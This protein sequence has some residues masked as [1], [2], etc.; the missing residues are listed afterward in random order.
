MSSGDPIAAARARLAKCCALLSWSRV[1]RQTR[2]L[3]RSV[4]RHEF[5]QRRDWQH[6]F[7]HSSSH[8]RPGYRSPH[9]RGNEHASVDLHEPGAV[10]YRSFAEARSKADSCRFPSCSISSAAV[11]APKNTDFP[12]ELQR[13]NEKSSECMSTPARIRLVDCPPPTAQYLTSTSSPER[14][15][16]PAASASRQR[17]DCTQATGGYCH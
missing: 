17:V 12:P 11:V 6:I 2:C 14:R 4:L 15:C 13:K 3:N 16:S 7:D 9:R 5:D 8:D 10:R 1:R